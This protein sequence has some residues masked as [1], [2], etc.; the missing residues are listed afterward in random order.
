VSVAPPLRIV[1]SRVYPWPYATIYGVKSTVYL[2][3]V[4]SDVDGRQRMPSASCI[5]LVA[6]YLSD[7]GLGRWYRLGGSPPIRNCPRDGVL[8]RQSSSSP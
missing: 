7:G 5:L 3:I 1:L 6:V 2:A 4:A 8:R